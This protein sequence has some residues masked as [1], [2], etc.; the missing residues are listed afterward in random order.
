MGTDRNDKVIVG[1]EPAAASAGEEVDPKG[2]PLAIVPSSV[3]WLEFAVFVA[4]AVILAWLVCLPLWLSGEGLGNVMLVQV[5][6][7]AM[8][9]TPLVAVVVA[10]FVQRRRTGEPRASIVRYLG[11]WPLR[12][13]GRVLGTTALAFFGIFVLVAAAYL[14]GAAFG[15]MQVDLLGLS[16]FKAQLA[17]LPGLDEV[18]VALAVIGYLV[19]MALG[20][21]LNVIV[22]FGEEVGWRGWLLTSLRPLGT[23]PAL[24]IVGVIWGLWHAPLI[25]LGYN[26]ARPDITGLAFMVGGCIMLGILFGWLRLRTGSIWPAVAAHAALNG[27]AGML[28]GLFIDGSAETPDMALVSFLGVSGWIVSAIVIAVLFAT[29]QFR[30]QPELG[31]KA[32][33]AAAPVPVAPAASPTEAPAARPTA[34]P[35]SEVL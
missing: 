9:F 2:R 24:I 34:A 30:K 27:S 29:G 23:W 22:A 20:S 13:F 10:M 19:I 28:L 35:S 17:Q 16:G 8:M 33:K 12:P 3:P 32:P 11:I 26:F 21:V 6:G 31:F 4:V 25:L 18:P 14:V 7:M 5:S 1:A 15:W